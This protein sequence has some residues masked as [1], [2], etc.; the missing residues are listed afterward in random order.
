MVHLSTVMHYLWSTIR[1]LYG[2]G[3][4]MSLGTWCYLFLTT[5]ALI[6]SYCI[7]HILCDFWKAL[8]AI[9]LF[10]PKLYMKLINYLMNYVDGP[11][12]QYHG[13][14]NARQRRRP[15]QQQRHHSP[16]PP[17]SSSSDISTD[18]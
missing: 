16:P 10:A 6:G 15:Q 9:V 13:R 7:M 8:G 11:N 2:L 1:V 18:R 14:K 12:C 17:N 3:T 4:K 5:T